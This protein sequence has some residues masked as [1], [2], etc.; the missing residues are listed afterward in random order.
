[1]IKQIAATIRDQIGSRALT[2]INARNLTA[3]VDGLSFRFTRSRSKNYMRIKLTG[4]DLYD[5]EYGLVHGTRYTVKTEETGLYFDMLRGSIERNT[6][7]YTS[8]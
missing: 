6:G 2:M 8:L 7:L 5:V 3:H 1:M 4:S